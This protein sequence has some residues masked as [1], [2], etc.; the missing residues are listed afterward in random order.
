MRV[1][2]WK[3]YRLNRPLLIAQAAL[4]LLIYLTGVVTQIVAAWPNTPTANDW[5]G[6]LLSYGTVALYLTFC[7]TGLLGGNAIACE[8]GDRSALFLASL[9][10]TRMQILASKL[11][12]AGIATT[13]LWGWI[14][15]S[16][17]VVGRRPGSEPSDLHNS[18]AGTGAASL[19]VL[20]FGVG[21]LCSASMEKTL[22][23]IVM[24]L[25][26]PIVVT[27]LLL[28]IAFVLRI[29]NVQI[30]GWSN[31]ICIGLGLVAFLVGTWTYCRREEP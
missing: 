4:L 31:P 25:V 11:I 27:V 26:S 23:P 9:P 13:L 10:P 29:P 28:L 1:L 22:L 8:R 15:L 18:M 14:L 21:W 5:A 2:L 19:C 7:F 16:L 12:V 3:D 20:T 24:A 17:Y 30:S 6:M